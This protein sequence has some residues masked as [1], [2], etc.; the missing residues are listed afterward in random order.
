MD[1][2]PFEVSE[3]TAAVISQ[4]RQEGRRVIAVGTTTTRVLESLTVEGH[5]VRPGTGRTGLFIYPE[6]GR[7]HV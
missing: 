3:E 1:P 6:I 2:E 5:R 4:A 7:A